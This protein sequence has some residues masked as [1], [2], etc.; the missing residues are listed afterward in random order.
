MDCDS[1]FVQVARLADPEGAGR[2]PLLLVGGRS[3]RGV[4]TSASYAAR[5]YGLMWA[6]T[7]SADARRWKRTYASSRVLY[8]NAER[9]ADSSR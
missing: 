8:W 9:N 3:D 4:I 6:A 1:F 7:G 2:E 5:E